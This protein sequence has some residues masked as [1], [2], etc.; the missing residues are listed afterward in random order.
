MSVILIC[1]QNRE[2]IISLKGANTLI[3]RVLRLY[4]KLSIL[5]AYLYNSFLYFVN[6]IFEIF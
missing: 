5:I 1:I 4:V 2:N 3:Y 6:N